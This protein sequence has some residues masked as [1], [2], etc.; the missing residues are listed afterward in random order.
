MNRYP[1][2]QLTLGNI[3]ISPLIT[4]EELGYTSSVEELI[5]TVSKFNY[6]DILIQLARINLLLQRS[7]DF[8][9]DERIL[10][11]NFCNPVRLCGIDSS[12]SLRGRFLFSR[13]STL[14]LLIE[15]AC[16]SDPDSTYTFDNADARYD[17]AKCYSI[18]NSLLDAGNS[19]SNTTSD[20]ELGKQIIVDSIPIIDYAINTSIAYRTK[21]LM[22]KTEEYLRRLI[23]T[24]KERLGLDANE[25]F[26]QGTGLT[27]QDYQHL[28]F[29]IFAYYWNFSTLEIV[30]QDPLIDKSLFYNTNLVPDLTPLY[31]KFLPYIRISLEDLKDRAGDSSGLKNEFLLWR[32]FPLIEI[33]ENQII[34]IDFYFLLEKLQTG[35]FWIIRDLLEEQCKG[36]G[37]KIIGLWGDIFENYAASVI[38]RGI[39]TQ[40]PPIE[41][42]ITGLQ[43]DQKQEKECTD[44]AVCSKDT[45]ILIE[46]KSP[47]IR[48]ESKFSGDSDKFDTELKDKIIEG[49][50]PK[51]AKGIK[52]LCN[53]IQSLFHVDDTQRKRIKEIDISKINRIYPILV[54]S[55]RMFSVPLMNRYLDSEFEQMVKCTDLKEDLD[56]KP[57]TVLTIEDLESLEPYL[58]DTPFHVHL[59]NW[60]QWRA[61]R[62]S[63]DK[64]SFSSFLYHLLKEDPRDNAFI[65]QKFNQ[66]NAEI[67]D[68][69]T[70]RGVE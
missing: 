55:D 15:C 22:V 17:L 4:A 59:D 10:K 24:G 33:S 70:E 37:Q 58:N 36:D 8:Q 38:T 31:K 7:N 25:I 35:V 1:R 66:I 48:A 46:C 67:M 11:E 56:I 6:K 3:E 23:K 44:I 28:V 18:A 16:I 39:D 20:E 2:K 62:S 51:K 40:E 5:K 12:T 50:R 43:Y 29:S 34:C 26:I 13:Q 30:R 69:F 41:Q 61:S 52:Q 53:A 14:R 47:I 19:A 21:F 60:I 32:Q 45:L 65:D 27:L 42:C 57:L 64:L 68:Y 63:N 54:L 49:E 9:N